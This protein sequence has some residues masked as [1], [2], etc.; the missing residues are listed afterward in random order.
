MKICG[1]CKKEKPLG[2]FGK[3]CK[4][5]DGLGWECK[6]CTH[7]RAKSYYTRPDIRAKKK[8]YDKLP[9][10]VAR[11]RVRENSPEYIAKRKAYRNRPEVI[12]RTRLYNKLPRVRAAKRQ[13][14]NNFP[15]PLLEIALAIQG[16]TCAIC[17]MPFALLESRH[18]HA[19]HCHKSHVPRGVLCHKC[20]TAIG[21]LG[22]DPA[23]IRAAADY[24]EDPPLSLI[25]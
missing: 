12:V 17:H 22:D 25:V 7:T 13:Y 15:Q 20:N 24:L 3:N 18:L 5:R 16:S 23:R 10:V 8:V 11:R 19:D 14:K 9:E 21:L 6:L 4:S 1:K 2:E